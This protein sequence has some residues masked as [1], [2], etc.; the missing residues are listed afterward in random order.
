MG[1]QGISLILAAGCEPDLEWRTLPFTF[2]DCWQQCQTALEATFVNYQADHTGTKY[3]ALLSF[4]QIV[5]HNCTIISWKERKK[6]Q[7]LMEV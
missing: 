2:L 1:H 6:A 4:L 3:S 7:F 5:N